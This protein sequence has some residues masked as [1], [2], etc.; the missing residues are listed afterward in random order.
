MKS[1]ETPG[2]DM[3]PEQ[4]SPER[5]PDIRIPEDFSDAE[6]AGI[7]ETLATLRTH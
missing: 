2:G 4:E 7:I 1:P 3:P 6:L 5:Q